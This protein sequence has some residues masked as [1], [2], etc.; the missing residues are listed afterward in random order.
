MSQVIARIGYGTDTAVIKASAGRTAFQTAYIKKIAKDR[1]VAY[2]CGDGMY[3]KPYRG[4][5]VL[6]FVTND[7]VLHGHKVGQRRLLS[8]H[9]P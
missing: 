5:F 4:P 9:Q 6:W 3:D 7:G 1:G 8:I 2:L